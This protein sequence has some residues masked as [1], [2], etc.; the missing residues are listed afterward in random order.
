MSPAPGG[1]I[2]E[3]THYEILGVSETATTAEIRIAW[4]ALIRDLH[5]DLETDE[6][7]KHE[8]N[9]QSALINNAYSTLT[10]TAER[11]RYDEDLAYQRGEH[12]APTGYE[13]GPGYESE[14][15]YTADEEDEEAMWE[16]I[17]EEAEAEAEEAWARWENPTARDRLSEGLQQVKRWDL[18]RISL[19]GPYDDFV[20]AKVGFERARPGESLWIT[21]PG[22]TA[23]MAYLMVGELLI[24]G[25]AALYSGF[26]ALLIMGSALAADLFLCV[27]G[28]RPFKYLAAAARGGP[29]LSEGEKL[30][31]LGALAVRS[32]WAGTVGVF[33]SALVVLVVRWVYHLFAP[34]T[35]A[36]TIAGYALLVLPFIWT[37]VFLT[38]WAVRTLSA[39]PARLHSQND[40][41]DQNG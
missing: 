18:S 38:V 34:A 5:P 20:E 37:L 36:E 28:A 33:V 23:I 13:S 17:Q 14:G 30:M 4:L 27:I 10:D 19:A 35:L 1:T 8:A 40:Q 21:L 22:F 15:A 24:G 29:P 11:S 3:P 9:R 2:N 6:A 32:V 7:A 16:R 41:R 12:T 31:A 39:R 25:A 26:G